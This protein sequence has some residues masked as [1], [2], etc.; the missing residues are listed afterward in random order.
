MHSIEKLKGVG[1]QLAKKFAIL[2]IHSLNDVIDY[3]PRTYVDYSH[4]TSIASLRPGTVTIEAKLVSITG[5]Y[6]RRGLHITEALV[7]DDTGS[8]KVVWFNQPFRA[9]SMKLQESYFMSGD[10][11]LTRQRMTLTSPMTEKKSTMP[12]HTAR[13]VPTYKETKGLTSVVIRKTV[14][15]AFQQLSPI[16][17]TLPAWLISSY[18]LMSK[19]D[20]LMQMHFP[21]SAA[22]LTRAKKRLGFEEI[23]YLALASLLNKKEFSKT[24]SV[25]IPFNLELA[26]KFVKSLPYTLT[27]DQRRVLWQIFKDLESK[28]PMNRLVE[29]DVGS[30]KTVVAAMAASMAM[31]AGYQVAYMAPTELLAR[32]H[33]QTLYSILESLNKQHT[34]CLLLGSL[35][36][37][38]KQIAHQRIASGEAQFVV[39]THAL[40]S[41]KVAMK[42][43]GLVIVDEQHRFGVDQRKKLQSKAGT[44]P[45]VLSMTAT[46]IPRSLALTLYGELDISIIAS[47]PNDRKPVLTKI[48]SPNSK[49]AMYEKVRTELAIGRQVFIVCPAITNSETIAVSVE[50]VY[51]EAVRKHFTDYSVGLLHGKLKA[52]EKEKIMQAF[53]DGSIQVLVATTVIEV[54]VNVPNATIMIIEGADRFGLAQM[55]Q[56]RGRVGRNELQ[57]YCYIVPSTSKEP[58]ARLQALVSTNDGF[59]LSE[60]DLEIRGPG[61]IYGTIQSGALDLRV[62]KLSDTKLIAEARKAAATFL[63]KGENLLHY[64]VVEHH[65]QRIRTITNLN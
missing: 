45:H 5:R 41:D 57:G 32:Q 1:P 48:V 27:D 17:E 52:E 50:A 26:K 22:L 43:L 56:L 35:K 30:G 23:F 31:E 10:Y 47:K 21:Q 6:V 58:S 42:K 25:H 39:G 4:I 44:L 15:Q 65:V 8:L 11:G 16:Q 64:P 34:V 38:E 60:L 33:A 54:G 19:Q 63:D 3:L 24:H 49:A 51:K 7:S 9:T 12:L 61:A 28:T 18:A 37:S 62:A 55:H 53:I 46:P 40:F 29:G 14:Q 59:T 13:I 36:K 20:A 2:G